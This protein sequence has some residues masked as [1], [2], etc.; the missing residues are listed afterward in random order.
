[1]LTNRSKAKLIL[2][3]F[4]NSHF[5][6]RKVCF[7]IGNVSVVTIFVPVFSA[8][9]GKTCNVNPVASDRNEAHGWVHGCSSICCPE[10]GSL[11]RCVIRQYTHRAEVL[12]L[13]YICL[14][15]D[16]R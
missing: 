14:D 2:L 15:M 5:R 4:N 11:T 1:M 10:V 6:Q 8:A 12:S 13:L 7:K 16:A 9:V 3:L